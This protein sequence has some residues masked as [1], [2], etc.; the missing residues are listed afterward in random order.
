MELKGVQPT[1]GTAN[2]TPN[3][4][5]EVSLKKSKNLLYP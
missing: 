4:S 5:P 2:G 3:G 1:N